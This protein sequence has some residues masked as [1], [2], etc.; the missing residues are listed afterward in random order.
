MSSNICAI[1]DGCVRYPVPDGPGGHDER[2][3]VAV[4]QPGTRHFCVKRNKNVRE[5]KKN[6][7]PRLS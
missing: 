5:R 3:Q 1:G 4:A 2:I 7:G 6:V